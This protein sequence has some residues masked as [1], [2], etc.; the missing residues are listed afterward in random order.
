MI[1]FSR[2][3]SGVVVFAMLAGSRGLSQAQETGVDVPTTRRA[4]GPGGAPWP[5]G[6]VGGGRERV[7]EPRVA[8]ASV[9]SGA[10]GSGSGAGGGGGARGS[11]SGAGP[12]RSP[13]LANPCSSCR[14][15]PWPRGGSGGGACARPGDD[16]G[17]GGR[18]GEGGRTAAEAG[19]GCVRPGGWARTAE[20]ARSS[21]LLQRPVPRTFR[22]GSRPSH[23][24]PGPP[25]CRDADL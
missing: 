24:L 25:S 20:G 4:L 23:P 12:G 16:G 6:R 22:C 5:G 11:V 19:R 1:Y 2:C 18:G 10:S 7:R 17:D 3:V 9:V 15:R 21:S 8:A 14:T 13:N